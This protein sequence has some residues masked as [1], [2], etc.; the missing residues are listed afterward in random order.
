MESSGNLGRAG[1]GFSSIR[2]KIILLPIIGILGMFAIAGIN[3]YLDISI[4]KQ[5]EAGRLTQAMSVKMTEMMM[6]EEKFI[7]TN[8]V[9]LLETRETL[10]DEFKAMLDNLKSLTDSSFVDGITQN[11]LEHSQIFDTMAGYLV[12]VNGAAQSLTQA[13]DTINGILDEIIGAIDQEE[14]DLM[15]EGETIDSLKVA[16]RKETI[17]YASLGNRRLLNIFQNLFVLND[18]AKYFNYKT[19]VDKLIELSQKNVTM[20]YKSINDS[21]FL[22]RWKDAQNE[23]RKIVE[24]EDE[25]FS[26]WQMWRELIP[27]FAKSVDAVQK[28]VLDSVGNT[29]NIIKEKG[30]TGEITSIVVAGVSMMILILLGGVVYRGV[31]IP[32]SKAVDMLKDIAEGEGD[33]TKRLEVRS[34]DEVG[35][36]AQWFNQFVERI[37][38]I[39]GDLAQNSENLNTSAHALAAISQ[40]MTQGAEHTSSKASGVAVSSEEMSSHFN[41]VAAA[42]EETATNMNQV[43]SATDQVTATIRDIAEHTEKANGMT[44]NAVEQ[45][46]VASGQMERLGSSAQEIGKVMESITDIG[47][48]VNLLA[49]NATIEAARAGEAGK[50][51]AVVANE[52]KELARQTTDASSEIK[53]RVEGIQSTT[54]ESMKEIGQITTVVNDINDIVST[55]AVAVEEQTATTQDISQNLAQ[56]SGGIDEVNENV[57]QSSRVADN[58]AREILDVT[59]AAKEISKSSTQVD[60]SASELLS[61]AEN[62]NTVVGKFKF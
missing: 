61:L 47:E 5:I 41:T 55:I 9:S 18:E 7:N 6:I 14:M 37:Q 10:Y 1:L 50:G 33:L 58:I 59:D 13:T 35:E 11:E 22:K 19:E 4:A 42:M 17:C 43:S 36:M 26:A 30:K 45:A 62:L 31:A 28:S 12:T 32:I 60:H 27:S 3:K 40:K 51:F 21:M 2:I 57:A 49:L 53:Q 16:A 8:N 20:M 44:L 23:S 29:Q 54:K 39:V 46:R 24:Y 52:I 56:A 38:L 34:Q 25:L 15:L 48:Q